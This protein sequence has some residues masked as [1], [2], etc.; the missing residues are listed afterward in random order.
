MSMAPELRIILAGIDAPSEDIEQK[1]AAR[2]QAGATMRELE[3]LRRYARDI[4]DNHDHDPDSHR[5]GTPC[6][7][8]EAEKLMGARK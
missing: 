1:A 4:V 7:V 6:F 8:C 5:Y 3:K 2:A